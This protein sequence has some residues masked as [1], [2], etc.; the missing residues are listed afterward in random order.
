VDDLALNSEQIPKGYW[1]ILPLLIQR[2]V[3][4]Q[5][6]G[7]MCALWH[8]SYKTTGL[9]VVEPDWCRAGGD[10]D[11]LLVD[12]LSFMVN[13][14]WLCKQTEQTVFVYRN[15]LCSI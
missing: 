2:S 14:N 6:T 3:L 12:S 1:A 5:K 11:W 7:K 15:S 9:E 8:Y 10:R 13:V 4:Q